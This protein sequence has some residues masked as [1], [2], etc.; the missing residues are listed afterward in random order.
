[1]KTNKL[2]KDLTDHVLHAE[3]TYAK[4]PDMNE[5]FR[6][7]NI[8]MDNTQKSVQLL[9]VEQARQGENMKNMDKNI[10]DIANKM[11]DRTT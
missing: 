3:Q 5:G 11:Q 7:L 2:Q 4:I 9:A 8:K 10:Q 6:I 1:M